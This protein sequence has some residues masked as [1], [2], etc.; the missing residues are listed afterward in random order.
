MK[1][2]KVAEDIREILEEVLKEKKINYSLV[3]E[4]DGFFVESELSGRQFHA[5]ISES[6]CLQQRKEKRTRTESFDSLLN[7]FPMEN[8]IVLQQNAD[9]VLQLCD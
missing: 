9:K 5:L 4:D 1:K 7:G 2:R 3:K 8:F 6:R